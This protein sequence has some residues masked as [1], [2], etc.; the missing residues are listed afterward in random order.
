MLFKKLMLMLFLV[1]SSFLQAIPIE[2]Q[3]SN[4]VY[5]VTK[6][7]GYSSIAV[8]CFLDY[9]NTKKIPEMLISTEVIAWLNWYLTYRLLTSPRST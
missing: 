2:Y 5:K 6:F 7:V 1:I 4:D 9:K 3:L 8:T